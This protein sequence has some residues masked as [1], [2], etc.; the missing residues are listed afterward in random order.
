M[1]IKLKLLKV[2]MCVKHIVS[3]ILPLFVKMISI[4]A[5]AWGKNERKSVYGE[6]ERKC[7]QQRGKM[8]KKYNKEEKPIGKL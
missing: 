7:Y 6:D 3:P 2:S 8:E 1:F 5:I 4:M